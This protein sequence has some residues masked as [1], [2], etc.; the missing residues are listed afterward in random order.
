[1]LVPGDDADHALL[2]ARRAGAPASAELLVLDADRP[3]IWVKAGV[4]DS[5]PEVDSAVRAGGRWYVM[6]TIA[7]S[8]ALYEIDGGT[9][10]QL[11]RIPRAGLDGRSEGHGRLARRDDGRAIGVVVDGQPDVSAPPSRWVLPVEVP[12]G[13]T[14]DPEPL[15]TLGGAQQAPRLCT[16]DDTGGWELGVEYAGAIEIEVGD[17]WSASLQSPIVEVRLARDRACIERVLGSANPY[18]ATAPAALMTPGTAAAVSSGEG[19]TRG[20]AAGPVRT[21]DV[22]VFSARLR[23]PLRCWPH[24][25]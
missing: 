5:F 4:G 8:T 20:G 14:G 9:A 16:G 3:P 25:P 17:G 11:R 13:V 15:A 7:A 1:V 10:R 23:Y 19:R 21:V 6:S 22:S 18:G 24:G 2:V 12:S